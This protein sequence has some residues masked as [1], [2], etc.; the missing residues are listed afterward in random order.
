MASRSRSC[1]A[2][3]RIGRKL[4]VHVQPKGDEETKAT[5]SFSR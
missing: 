3:Q 2:Q 4:D 5:N 1:T